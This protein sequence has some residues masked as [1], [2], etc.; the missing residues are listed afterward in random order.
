LEA[1]LVLRVENEKAMWIT[2]KRVYPL[3]TALLALFVVA[4]S[5]L[6]ACVGVTLVIPPQV[7]SPFWPGD[8]FLVGVLLSTPRRIWPA[9]VAAG[10]AGYV[11]QSLQAGFSAWTIVWGQA[12]AAI[13]ILIAALGLGYSF[14]GVPSL[15]SLKALGKFCLFALLLAPFVSSFVGAMAAPAQASYWTEC[16]TWFLG[17]VLAFLTVTPA[18]LSWVSPGSEWTNHR[19]WFQLEGA[20]LIS[21][22]VLLGYII[23]FLHWSTI[24]P[25]L[26]YSLVPFLLWS[27]L[28]FGSGGV[29]TS[30]MVIA[31]SSIWGGV[32]GHSPFPGPDPLRNVLSLQLFLLFAAAPFMLLAVVVEERQHAR[33]VEKELSGRLISAQEQERSR[34][35]RELHD[36]ICQR[37]ALLS[38]EIQRANRG[39]NG[40]AS[41]VKQHLDEIRMHCSEI[42]SDVQALS[43]E[44]HS[45]KLDYLGIATAIRAFCREFGKQHEVS[46]E[47]AERN[48]PKVMPKDGSL[49]LFRIA[50]E[51][52]HNAVK[53]SGTRQFWVELTGTSNQVQLEVRDAGVGF[54]VQAA[55]RNG[56]LGL[57]SMRERIRVVDGR[58]S[59]ES[60]PGAGTRIVASVPRV[61][62]GGSSQDL[63]RDQ[64]A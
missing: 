21:G 10:L 3:P 26:L 15:N 14:H 43:H 27:A 32:H 48:V 35:A 23:F 12:G 57:V 7:M 13:A 50:Q 9:L 41:G 11:L 6:L 42:A 1:P 55:S 4:G 34:I 39:E 44:L 58:F 22:L 56:G 38:I 53:Y 62:S 52:L 64:A 45:A 47:F 19:P 16:R 28:R 40:V 49:C 17:D 30:M 29:G 33:L 36:D 25:A 61:E 37:L 59:L 31:F 2:A 5:Y 20:A 63:R 8:A 54:D 18:F 46:I 24:P 60:R 51:A